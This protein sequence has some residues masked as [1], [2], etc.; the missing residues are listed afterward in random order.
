MKP[1]NKLV[2]PFSSLS[3]FKKL[4]HLSVKNSRENSLYELYGR[5]PSILS[6]NLSIHPPRI[7][8]HRTRNVG[9]EPSFAISLSLPF[10]FSKVAR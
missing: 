10:I 4:S 9:T 8:N 7:D 3:S 6:E 5:L 1:E 2:P